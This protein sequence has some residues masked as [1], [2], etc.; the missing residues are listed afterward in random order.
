MGGM[1][2]TPRGEDQLFLTKVDREPTCEASLPSWMSEALDGIR[3]EF[4]KIDNPAAG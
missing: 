2:Q 1:C 3:D 4:G